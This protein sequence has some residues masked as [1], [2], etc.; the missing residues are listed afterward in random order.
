MGNR[1]FTI[2]DLKK[3]KLLMSTLFSVT[4]SYSVPSSVFCFFFTVL[5]STFYFV[6]GERTVVKEGYLFLSCL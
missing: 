4:R 6:K 1:V 3:A 2:R 5:Y